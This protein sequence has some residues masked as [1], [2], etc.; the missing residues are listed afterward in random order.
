MNPYSLSVLLF[1]FGVLLIAILA[2]VRDCSR[3]TLRFAGFSAMVVGWSFF[4][5]AWTGYARPADECLR[6]IRISEVFAVFIPALWMHFIFD[7]VGHKPAS[8]W[9]M[10]ANYLISVVFAA[11]CPTPYFFTGVQEVPV[12]GWYKEGGPV[13]YAF[14]AYFCF[15]VARAFYEL[16]RARALS[17]GPRKTQLTYLLIGWGTA[18]LG[19]TATFLPAMGITD[20]YSFFFL[21]PLYPIFLGVALTQF[22]YLDLTKITDSFHKDKLAAVG[23]L[24]ACINHEIRNPVFVIEGVSQL[25]LEGHPNQIKDPAVEK[26]MKTIS[27]QSRRALEIMRN[28]SDFTKQEISSAKPVKAP[29]CVRK[30]LADVKPLIRHEFENRDIELHEEIPAE[31]SSVSI[32]KRHLEEILFNLLLNASQAICREPDAGKRAVKIQALQKNGSV[33]LQIQD[34]GPGISEAQLPRIFEPFYS[35]REAGS[36][37][38]LFITKRLVE[39]NGGKILVH[40][41]EGEGTTFRLT[42]PRA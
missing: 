16:F 10:P 42:F 20:F 22:G 21:M 40:S 29:V 3:I 1:G 32:N 34:N 41:R 24:S 33:V 9:D 30:T 13:F 4:Y 2:L 17:E 23:T 14:F 26:A 7:F 38:G 39:R 25:Y 11:F 5:T 37:L 27:E 8:H 6:L 28:L 31:L 15:S 36:G 12:F 19:G 35:T 18:F